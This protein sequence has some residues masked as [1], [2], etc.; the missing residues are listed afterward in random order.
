MTT[1]SAFC[2]D[3][4]GTMDKS[5]LF[6][7]AAPDFSDPLGL[8]RACH[9]RILK[10]GD[11]AVNLACRLA[12]SGLD[13]EVTNA[14]AQ[15]HRYFST[16]ARHHHED[17]EQEIFPRLARQSRKLADLVHSLEQEH[18]RLEALWLE[19]EPLLAEPT[20]IENTEEFQSLAKQ[21]AEAH[22]AHVRKENSELLTQ[23]THIFSNGEL[24]E[25][26]RSMAERRGIK[27]PQHSVSV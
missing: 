20:R 5:E 8:L 7:P 3:K 23:A 27:L 14:A 1:H 11:M 6:P 15:V 19:M 12:D 10:H 21:F 13:P 9:E 4:L 18:N 2:P 25:I 16:A 24:M 17:E 22:R 26:G